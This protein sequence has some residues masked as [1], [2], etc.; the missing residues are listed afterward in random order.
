MLRIFLLLFF[1]PLLAY[2]QVENLIINPS[3]EVDEV[4]LD[5][6]AWQ[7]W[8]TWGAEKGL[9]SKVA[10]D[11]K[12]FIDGS[13]SLRIEP[14]GD[15][16]WHFIVLNLPINVSK[17]K[18][19]TTSFWAKAEKDR[20]IAAKLKATDNSIDFCF[21]NLGP[22]TTEWKEYKFT[23]EPLVTSIKMEMFCAGSDVPFWLDLVNLY[24]GKP[25]DNLLPS[26]FKVPKSVSIKDKLP[27]KWA[28]IKF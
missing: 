3:F 5:D 12:E 11:T 23:C 13:R 6:P 4:I 25:V 10:I 18:T 22:I 20:P 7:G 28:E 17:G 24:L 16:D 27:I 1:V 8:A 26:K 21:T 19:Y 15:I 9:N 2:A 14:K